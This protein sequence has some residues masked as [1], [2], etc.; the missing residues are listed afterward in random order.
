MLT[1]R[2]IKNFRNDNSFI[3]IIGSRHDFQI[4]HD[5]L[6]E[7]EHFSLIDETIFGDIDISPLN[8]SSFHLNK[9]EISAIVNSFDCLAK[10]EEPMHFYVDIDALEDIEIFISNEQYN[11]LF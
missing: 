11:N 10:A 3:V 6:I 7:N 8:V 9:E 4:A 2:Y 1:I 5:L